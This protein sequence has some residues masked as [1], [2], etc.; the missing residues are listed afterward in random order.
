MS[1]TKTIPSFFALSSL[2]WL[3]VAPGGILGQAIESR[4]CLHGRVILPEDYS[5]KDARTDFQRAHSLSEADSLY[6]KAG[7]FYHV[8]LFDSTSH[9]GRGAKAE[10]LRLK[11]TYLSKISETILGEWHWVWAGTI[12][13]IPGETPKSCGCTKKMVIS[14]DSIVIYNNGMPEKAIPYQFSIPN[15]SLGNGSIRIQAGDQC[16]N[17]SIAKGSYDPFAPNPEPGS[18]FLNINL[19]SGCVCGCR[20]DSYERRQ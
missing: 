11:E 18:V 9:M 13:Y 20:T 19:F 6:E 15:Y 4:P 16:W 2:F 5:A 8:I 3:L 17:L 10:W 1:R 14:K 7:L 12:G